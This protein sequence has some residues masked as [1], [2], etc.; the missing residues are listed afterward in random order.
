VNRRHVIAGLTLPLLARGACAQQ[1][2]PKIGFL[3]ANTPATAGH[4]T[5]AFIKRLNE[6]GWVEGRNVAIVY[7]WAA[8]QDARFRELSAELVA[9]QVDVIVTSGTF[10]ALAA[11]QVTQSIPIVMASSASVL[12]V[13]L[14]DSIARPGGNVTGLTFAPEDTVGKRLELLKALVPALRRIGILY[15]PDAN[16]KEL[17]AT[18]SAASAFGLEVEELAFKRPGDLDEIATT[19]RRAEIGGLFVISDPLV[20]VHRVAINGVALRE[21]LATM[22]RLKEYVEDGGLAS[23]G[24]HFPDFFR[25]AADFVDKIL[26]GAKPALRSAS[27]ALS[28]RLRGPSGTPSFSRSLSV[29]SGRSS[30]PISLSRN[31][32]S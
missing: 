31:V 1:P 8:R 7:R 4:L 30:P 29:S 21:R 12:G 16:L 15:N 22:H 17:R 11:R 3:G 23:Y 13:G 9:E 32:P 20:F 5:E 2:L 10:P 24:P 27:M 19:G 14:V 28:S 26:R 18:R 6:L 25:Y